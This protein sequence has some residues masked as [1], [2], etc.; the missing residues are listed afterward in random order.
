MTDHV[1]ARIKPAGDPTSQLADGHLSSADL[2]RQFAPF[3]AS[4]LLRMGIRRA[5]LDDVIQEV[6]LVAHKLGG[7]TPGAAKP[8][9]YLANIA[10]RAATTHRRK[11]QVRSFVHVNEEL[12]G[13]ASGTTDPESDAITKSRLELL[14]RALDRLDDDKRAIFV[15]CEIQGE[16]VVAVASGLGI[17]VD[18]AYSR[19]RAAR[20]L[21]RQAVEELGEQRSASY[22]PAMQRART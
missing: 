19:L 17:P 15:L 10:L 14:H 13:T 20:K 16:T 8:T 6:F 22:P 4:F 11:G 3:V 2:Y 12:V 9:T 7:Y 18:T 5:D 1:T 21:F